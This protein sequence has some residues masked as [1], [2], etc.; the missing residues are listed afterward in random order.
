MPNG[1]E[2]A[3]IDGSPAED[4]PLIRSVGILI[5]QQ[6]ANCAPYDSQVESERPIANVM[7]VQCDPVSDVFHSV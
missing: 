7:E 3:L 5:M 4:T 6:D 1:G 2:L